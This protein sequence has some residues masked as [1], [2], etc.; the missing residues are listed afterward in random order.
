MGCRAPCIPLLARMVLGFAVLALVPA[1]KQPAT[2]VEGGYRRVRSAF[3]LLTPASGATNV[4]LAPSF[5]WSSL[6]AATNYTLEVSPDPSFG[7]FVVNQSG[8]T[9]TS[10]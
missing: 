3:D 8:I 4:P 6:P 10:V 2:F 7:S 1:C 9:G 5:S